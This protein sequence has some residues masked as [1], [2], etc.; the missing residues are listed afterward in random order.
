MAGHGSAES[1]GAPGPHAGDKHRDLDDLFLV[2]DH[3]QRV[4]E[5]G[6][7]QRMR[8]GDLL[9]SLLAPDI[10]MD[11]V[12]LDR[13]R[14]DDGHLDHEVVEGLRPRSW[15]GLHLRTRL[16]LED[17]DGVRLAAH[18]EHCGVLQR[19]L[20]EVRPCAGRVLDQLEG[21]G[22][23]RQGA[24]AQH[25]HLDQAQVFDVVLVE[26]DDAAPFHRRGLDRRDVDQWLAGDEHAAVVDREVAGKLD[27]LAAQLEELL[28]ALR[29]HI[30]WGHR[31]SHRVLD[32]FGKPAVYTFGQAV[33]QL[34]RKAKRFADLADRHPRLEGD[35]VADHPG[36]LPAVLLV[37]VLDDLLAMLGREIDVDVRCAGHLLV[38]KSLE[39]KVVFDRVDARDAKHVGDDR[40]GGRAS[41]LPRHTVVAGEAHQVP[42]DEEELGEPRLLDHLQLVL[43]AACDHRSNRPVSLAEAF[44]A[45]LVEKG[46]RR[47]SGGH[48]VSG[49]PDLAKVEVDVTLLRDLPR[50]GQRLGMALEEK[51]HLRP[52]LQV[53]LRVREKA[54]P[55]VLEG[56]AV[57]NRDQ[58][59]VHPAACGDVVMNL[60][61][62]DH[63]CAAT[64]RCRCPTFEH[65]LVFWAHVVVQFAEDALRSE[66]FLEVAQPLFAVSGAEIEE[67]SAMLGDLRERAPGFAFGLVGVGDAEE[68]A[69]VRVA[70]QVA[71][72]QDQLFAVDLEC[73]PD[74]GFD[75]HLSACLEV[76]HRAVNTA[77]VG[78]RERGH[79]ELGRAHGQLIGMRA[80][81]Q[82]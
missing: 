55:C 49:K 41:A 30:G 33:E 39:E 70:A 51:A 35:D 76:A 21:F 19:Q 15:Q 11:G 81:V 65:P 80:A 61:G 16:D 54:R 59:V 53:V 17:A 5:N 10:G 18:L 8:I 38:Q 48:G 43:Q 40:V 79:I 12:A 24:Q 2:Q 22:H 26:L 42:V 25:V 45:K 82:E 4:F 50:R 66:R 34:G 7:E 46:E 27:D 75:A 44:E 62:H 29:P 60:V 58:H 69:E 64:S 52:A 77:L 71:R 63:A 56:G 47:L 74:D 6:L 72:E 28:P 13:S 23:H 67:V 1:V 73:A 3:A 14:P 32:V 20:V 78:D 37:D 31:T 9:A 36:P 57:T 68:A